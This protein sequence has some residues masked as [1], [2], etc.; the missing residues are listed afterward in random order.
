MMN[1]LKQFIFIKKEITSKTSGDDFAELFLH[2]KKDKKR[3]LFK[4][5]IHETNVE[6]KVFLKNYKKE[7]VK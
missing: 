4:K 7:F 2:T 3:K 6:Q 5:I 1:F